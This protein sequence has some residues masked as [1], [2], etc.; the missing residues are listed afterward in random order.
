MHVTVV[1]LVMNVTVVFLV[2]Y[3]A[4]VSLNSYGHDGNRAVYLNRNV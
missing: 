1:L 3:V 2:I 4:I